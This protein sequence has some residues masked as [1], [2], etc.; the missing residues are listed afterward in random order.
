MKSRAVIKKGSLTLIHQ[1]TSAGHKAYILDHNREICK[2]E[3]VGIWLHN[4]FIAADETGAIY[5]PYAKSATF[6]TL[7]MINGD[8]AQLGSFK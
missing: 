2:G 8:F 5:I 4:K 7:I 6:C 3:R 1:S